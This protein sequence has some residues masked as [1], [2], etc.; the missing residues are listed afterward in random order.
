MYIIFFYCGIYKIAHVNMKSFVRIKF[1]SQNII[2][3]YNKVGTIY[4]SNQRLI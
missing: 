2:K 4:V 1:V 3:F